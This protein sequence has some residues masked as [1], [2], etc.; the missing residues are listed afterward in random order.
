MRRWLALLMLPVLGCN[1]GYGVVVTVTIPTDV[2]RAFSSQQPGLLMDQWAV[3]ARLCDPTDAPFVAHLSYSRSGRCTELDQGAESA[4]AFRLA[5]ND[6]QSLNDRQK[7]VLN[8]GQTAP[9]TDKDTAGAL[10][11]LA[12]YH[13]LGSSGRVASGSAGSCDAKGSYVADITLTLV[14]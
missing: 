5:P 13:G 7:Q 2:Q 4:Y 9:I 12:L 14:P 10:V 3:L 8:C 6:L 11:P 1:P